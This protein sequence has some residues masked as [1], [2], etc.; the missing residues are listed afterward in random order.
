MQLT[1]R[2]ASSYLGV[3]EA[4]A[5]RWIGERALP[6]HTVDERVYLN[7]VELWEWAVEHGVQVSRRLLEHARR[8]PD[9][10]P[11]ISALLRAGGIF[12]DVD[13]PDKPSVLREFVGRLPLPPEQNR[14][15]L[16]SVLEAREAMGSTGI[17]DGI[18]IPHVRNP[19]VLHVDRP[20]VTL[21][22]LK[23]PID[24]DAIDGKPVHALFMVV[25]PTVPV[26]LRILGQLGFL[27][28]DETLRGLLKDRAAADAILGRMEVL[29]STRNTGSYPSPSR[30]RE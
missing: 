4:T 12:H 18:A 24:F 28:R 7:A 11:P 8:A 30:N 21:C 3:T 29:E 1:L 9:E 19:I 25:S 14:E 23:H 17:G 5:R 15:A 27:F 6:V 20:F 2:E 10:V 22:L 13:A 26:H 16:L